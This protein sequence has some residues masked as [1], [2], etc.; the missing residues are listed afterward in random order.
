MESLKKLCEAPSFGEGLQSVMSLVMLEWVDVEAKFKQVE[1]VYHECLEEL[2]SK[3][4][5]LKG[6]EESVRKGFCEEFDSRRRWIEAGLK[7][8]DE[9]GLSLQ[10]FLR[11]IEV[12]KVSFEEMEESTGKQMK[13]LLLMEG[14]IQGALELKLSQVEKSQIQLDFMETAMR[15]RE[16]NTVSKEKNLSKTE[17][18]LE[19]RRNEIDS[20]E[21]DMKRRN[22]LEQ[23]TPEADPMSPTKSAEVRRVGSKRDCPDGQERI[24][25]EEN[26]CKHAKGNSCNFDERMRRFEAQ[27]VQESGANNTSQAQLPDDIIVFDTCLTSVEK[28]NPAR[29]INFGETWACFDA[30]DDLPRTYFQVVNYVEEDGQVM[31]EAARL[32]PFPVYEGDKEWIDAGLPV[33]CGMFQ[34]GET[35][36]E[37]PAIFSHRIIC[38]R[39]HPCVILPSEGET[40]AIYKDWD[41]T[42]WLHGDREYDIVEILKIIREGPSSPSWRVRVGYLDRIIGSENLFKR[43]SKNNGD[44]D[45]TSEL[46]STS[47]YRFSHKVPYVD[48]GGTDSIFELDPKCF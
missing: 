29:T 31:L 25:M 27:D 20:E 7:R 16:A 39:E 13:N 19:R 14:E 2:E 1:G 23:S 45:S 21:E 5:H 30:N 28:G 22:S 35:S 48:G 17:G 10:G 24:I 40:W 42:K 18:I 46:P 6:V 47:I 34:R 33:T 36:V 12:E 38:K 11:K 8:L 32:E 43:R 15:I 9:K 37:S 3:E 44:E 26:R 41:I 4:K